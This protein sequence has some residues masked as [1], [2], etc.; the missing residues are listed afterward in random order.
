MKVYKLTGRGRK[1]YAQPC[2]TRNPIIDH[3]GEFK[4]ATY[5]ELCSLW[6]SNASTELNFLEKK[7]KYVICEE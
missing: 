2:A 6:G 1:F 3:L 7:K 4:S 5:D